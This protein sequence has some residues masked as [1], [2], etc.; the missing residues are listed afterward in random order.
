MH[1]ATIKIKNKKTTLINFTQL[2][3]CILFFK[4]KQVFE[5]ELEKVI[6]WQTHIQMERNI[7]ILS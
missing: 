3:I 4:S 7:P 5:K 6:T 1:G 2:L